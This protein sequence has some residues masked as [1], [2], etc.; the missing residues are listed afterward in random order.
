MHIKMNHIILLIVLLSF[1]VSG[2]II[3]AIPIISDSPFSFFGT[4]HILELIQV[5]ILIIF[6]SL[7]LLLVSKNNSSRLTKLLLFAF[8]IRV[9]MV[10]MMSFFDIFAFRWDSNWDNIAIPLSEIW[11]N[12]GFSLE[13]S[14]SHNVRYYTIITTFVFFV[15]S[16]NPIFMQIINAF[17]GT[18]TIFILY[19]LGKVLFDKNV[20]YLSS[21]LLTFWPTHILFSAMQMREA[22][23]TFTIIT[24]VYFFVLWLK[25]SKPSFL[26][27]A[28]LFMIL[29]FLF[30][31]RNGGLNLLLISPFIILHIKSLSSVK[32]KPILIFTSFVIIIVGVSWFY[33]AG[34][35]SYLDVDYAMSLDRDPRGGSAYLAWMEYSTPFHVILYLP[36]RLIYYLFSPF[37][38]QITNVTQLLAFF[39][40]IGLFIIATIS[41]VK[42]KL[43]Y[44]LTNDKK[45]FLFVILVFIT[46]IVAN[47]IFDS[48]TGTAMRHRVQ[49]I[50]VF[51]LLFSAYQVFRKKNHN[52]QKYTLK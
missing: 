35:L 43:I 25:K 52:I 47:S 15:F 1:I 50:S 40:A 49:Y 27:F 8:I 29:N 4:R 18:L 16:P 46:H 48:N 19:K 10:F 44:Y 51:L 12:Q 11:S 7:L 20:A 17:F 21:V 5:I 23:S 30:R 33:N 24:F 45:Q 38:W 34:Y 13:F 2:F 28:I 31:W 32:L 9:S 3:F 22:L 39:E 37:P 6:L 36:L 42:F 26:L 14:S 41:I